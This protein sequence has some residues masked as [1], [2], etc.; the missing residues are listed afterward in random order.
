MHEFVGRGSWLCA[1][2]EDE[3]AS[4][5]DGGKIQNGPNYRPRPNFGQSFFLGLNMDQNSAVENKTDNC[6]VLHFMEFY[7]FV[8][9]SQVFNF[10]PQVFVLKIPCY[11]FCTIVL[12]RSGCC[13]SGGT[14]AAAA[15]HWQATY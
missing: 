2:P 5:V 8:Q 7:M 6:F 9:F 3:G 10:F 14:A 12:V 1:Q 15:Q 13:C 4:D 11:D